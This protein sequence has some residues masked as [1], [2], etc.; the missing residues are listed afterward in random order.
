MQKG[1][2]DYS[3]SLTERQPE[4]VIRQQHEIVSQEALLH[5]IVNAVPNGLL[6]LNQE[7]QSILVNRALADSLALSDPDEAL[8]QRPGELLKCAH[9]D[10][11]PYGCGTAD[12]CQTCGAFH[13]ILEGLKGRQNQHEC[14]VL[15]HDGVALDLRISV[16]PYV[17]ARQPLLIFVLEDI[18]AEKRREVMER[19]FFHDVLNTANLLGFISEAL[20]GGAPGMAERASAELGSVVQQLIE[21][22]R[23]Q[24]DLLS[25]E[26]QDLAVRVEAGS[27]NSVMSLLRAGFA[28]HPQAR[29]VRLELEETPPDYLLETDWTLLG[30]VLTNL[31]KNALEASHS[32]DVVTVRCE[33]RAGEMCFEVANPGVMPLHVQLQM[34]KRSFS[35]KGPGRGIGTYSVKLM[36]EQYLYGKASFVSTEEIGTVFRVALPVKWPGTVQGVQ[37]LARSA[38]A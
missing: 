3:Y 5:N 9:A 15:R 19:V 31:V 17:V 27:V 35:T 18:S 2:L 38:E 16:T 29:K 22:L 6:I 12:A 10:S 37:R 26:R 4:Q 11:T 34:F 23:A 33:R 36:T 7:R 32:G 1:P 24:R 8:G 28:R 30:R 21:E 13:A 20:E 25:A 14:R